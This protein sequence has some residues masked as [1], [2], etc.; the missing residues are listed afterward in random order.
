[1]QQSKRQE[2]WERTQSSQSPGCRCREVSE[3]E[4]SLVTEGE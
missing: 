4:A 2:I 1:M 3:F